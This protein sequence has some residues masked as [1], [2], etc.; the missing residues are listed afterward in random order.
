MAFFYKDFARSPKDTSL[1]RFA[2]IP[3]LDGIERFLG[4]EQKLVALSAPRMNAPTFAFT[5]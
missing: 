2:G 4:D 1:P 3:S 5:D